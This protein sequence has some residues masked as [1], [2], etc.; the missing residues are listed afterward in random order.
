MVPHARPQKRSADCATNIDMARGATPPASVAGQC[1]RGSSGSGSGRGSRSMHSAGAEAGAW[2]GDLARQSQV[3]DKHSAQKGRP[4]FPVLRAQTPPPPDPP[5]HERADSGS[6]AEAHSATNI[7]HG[8]GVGSSSSS[9]SSSS[10]IS[11]CGKA[12][13]EV[14]AG[15]SANSSSSSI[16]T[17]SRQH[18]QGQP[19][20]Q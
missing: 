11:R 19:Q 12:G 9:S 5:V 2:T 16:S 13:D 18:Q 3:R 20:A 6:T 17:R 10:S 1:A 8:T 15:N 14:D 7:V 4:L